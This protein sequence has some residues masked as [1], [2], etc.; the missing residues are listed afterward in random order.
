MALA[1]EP[2]INMGVKEVKQTERWLDRGDRGTANPARI[3]NTPWWYAPAEAEVLSTF[4]LH[5]GCAGARKV[6]I[7]QG[8]ESHTLHGKENNVGPRNDLEKEGKNE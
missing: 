4:Q 2:M 3:S 6:L 7:D 1:I 5:R 8:C